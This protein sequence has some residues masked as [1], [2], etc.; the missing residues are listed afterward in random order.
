MYQK[1]YKEKY[2][3]GRGNFGVATL[4]TEKSTQT[5]YIAKKISLSSLSDY[6]LKCCQLEA[7]LLESLNHSCIVKYKETI[8]EQGQLIIIME[9]CPGGDLSQ[10]IK[11]HKDSRSFFPEDQISQWM[12]QM[13]SALRYLEERRV[14]HRDI[15]SSN[16][17]LTEDGNLKLGDFGIATILTCTSDVAKTVV[18]TPY[19]MSPEVCENKPYTCKSD[20]W[21][22]GCLFYELAAL[23]HPFTGTSFLALVMSILKDDPSELPAVYSKEFKL[24]VKMMLEKSPENRLSSAALLK[25]EYFEKEEKMEEVYEY[26]VSLSSEEDDCVQMSLNTDCFGISL[27]NPLDLVNSN[28]EASGEF[29]DYSQSAIPTF[30]PDVEVIESN[31][32]RTSRCFDTNIEKSKTNEEEEYE[33]DFES[34]IWI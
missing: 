19:Y 28:G 32:F 7:K 3:I 15:K 8:L 20:I 2:V 18:G 16:V 25:L 27:V 22:L 14:I 29:I 10:L 1:I 23:R 34:V 24:I 13:L 31:V 11:S 17:Y 33:D 4:V 6:E 5:D 26:E 9:Y 30:T 21:S 12:T